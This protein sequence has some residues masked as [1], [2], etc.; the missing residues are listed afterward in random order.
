MAAI[1]SL[2]GHEMVHYREGVHKVF[3]SIPF[4]LMFYTHFHDEHVRGHHKTV[5][6]RE[7]PTFAPIGTN[8][9]YGS[10]TSIFHTHKTTWYREVERITRKNS[11][12][13]FLGILA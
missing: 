7:D 1:A 5:G 10:F 6:T 11:N 2:A 8:V 9:Y 3:G 12:V 4:A 13:S